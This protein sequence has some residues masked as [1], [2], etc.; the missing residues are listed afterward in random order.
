[1]T[2]EDQE[3]LDMG[4]YVWNGMTDSVWRRQCEENKGIIRSGGIKGDS[5]E[6]M[7]CN[8]YWRDVRDERNG[9]TYEAWRLLTMEE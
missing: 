2:E 3:N 1:M 5:N 4:K 7:T 6:E 9:K 8:G